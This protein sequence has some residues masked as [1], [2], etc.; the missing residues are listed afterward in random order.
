MNI[1]NII[2]LIMG[3]FNLIVGI[4]WTKK[5]VINFVFKLLFLAGGGHVLSK[6]YEKRGI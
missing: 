1:L 3:I 2:L 6:Q 5:N 4:T